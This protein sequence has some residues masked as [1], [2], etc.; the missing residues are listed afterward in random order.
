MAS[1]VGHA[2]AGRLAYRA[3][4]AAMRTRGAALAWLCVF[5]AVAP[6]LDFLPGAMLG[7]PA[8][9]HQG[10]SH[11]LA[12]AVGFSLL[13]A[14]AYARG[15]TR[16]A[17]AWVPLLLSYLSHLLLDLFGP[18]HRPPYG[19]PLFWPFSH[20]TYLSPVTLLPGFHHADRTGAGVGEWLAGVFQM[21]NLLAL[22][23][24]IA[25]FA[26]AVILVELWAARRGARAPA[27]GEAGNTDV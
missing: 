5:A 10:A 12:A 27:L 21:R 8:L 15:R 20:A 4:G 6:D 19:I 14:V 7:R 25:I 1:P 11:S 26:P 17:A 22:G 9:F 13:L 16:L 23:I 24:E 2:L 18:D 3:G